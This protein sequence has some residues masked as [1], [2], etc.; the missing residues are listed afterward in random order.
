MPVYAIVETGGKQYRVSEGDRIDVEKL[1]AEPGSQ[2]ELD[3]V[4]MV[5]SDSETKIG[6][7]VVSGAK[8]V[9]RVAAQFRGPK[10]RVFKMKPKKRY[11]RR[12][13]HRQSLTRLVIEKI[14]A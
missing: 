13:G 7:P 3:R 10:I 12:I 5:V 11:R 8:V 1:E 6:N 2:V 14:E 9:A 4:L